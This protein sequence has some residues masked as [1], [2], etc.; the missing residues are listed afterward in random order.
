MAITLPQISQPM[1]CSLVDEAFDDPHWIFEPKYDGLRVI[2]RF[3]GKQITLLSRNNKPQNF[4]FPEI[5][6]GLQKALK[7]PAILDGEIVCLDSRGQA[8]FRLLQQRFHLTDKTEVTRRAELYPAYLYVFDILYFDRDDL[9]RRPL[10]ERKRVLHRAVKWSD[11]IRETPM[12]SGKGLAML[13]KTCA[14]GGEGIVA[15]KLDSFYTGDRGGAWLKI[16]CSG[17]Q[18]FV[19][20]GFTD[21]QKSR[22]GLGALLVGYYSDDG[23]QFIYAGKVGTGFTNE[24]LVDL[25]KRLNELK[26]IDNPFDAGDPPTRENVHWVDPKLVAEIAY[27]E[28]TQNNLLRQP[29]YEGLRPDKKAIQVR[30]EK[31][32]TISS[33]HS[34]EQNMSLE[35]YKKK[36]DFKITSEPTAKVKK[37]KGK[38]IFVIQEHH[39]TRLHWDFRLEAEGVLKSWAVTNEPTLDPAIKRLAVPTEDHPFEYAKFHGEIP[40]GQYGGGQVTI[41]DNGT[42]E[43]AYDTASIDD[44]VVRGIERGKLSIILHGKKLKGEY[45]LVR[46]HGG[47]YEGNWLMIKANDEFAKSNGASKSKPAAAKKVSRRK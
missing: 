24:T 36:R 45:A 19:I 25:S 28:W 34:S 39:A 37:S 47:K 30:R 38:R 18:E 10:S 9:T 5:V 41:W 4:Q 46:M 27:A 7:K 33:K 23:K 22:V 42:Y 26:I 16:K 31:P 29:R 43:M 2:C 12:T 3:D 32:K 21:P 13:K 11:R 40:K 17:R 44:E 20:G 1:L 8:S 6:A 15:K 35:K 14:A